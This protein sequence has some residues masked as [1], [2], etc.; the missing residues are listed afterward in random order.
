MLPLIEEH[1]TNTGIKAETVIGD[2]KYGTIENFLTCH[3]IG[4]KAHIPDLSQAAV[5]RTEGRRIFTENQFI[6]QEQSDTY[7]CPAGNTMKK[8]SLHMNRQSMDYGASKK[9]CAVCS[10]REQCTENKS[11][12]TIKRHLRQSELDYMRETSRSKASRRDIRTRQHLMER[13][14]AQSKRYGYDRARWRGLWRVKIQEYLTC[15][16]QNIQVLVKYGYSPKK[17]LAM[18][19]EQVKER[20]T[21]VISQGLNSIKPCIQ[22][23]QQWNNEFGQT[24]FRE[25]YLC[26]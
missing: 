18:V 14:F 20:V 15:A 12:R 23:I 13:S 7:T 10:I 24:G 26:C 11:G 9:V 21:M 5:K 22:R 17:G 3:D 1:K 8:K 19:M 4:I 16:I 2:S 25:T 6:Y